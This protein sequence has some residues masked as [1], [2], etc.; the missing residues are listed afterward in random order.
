MCGAYVV[1]RYL[2]LAVMAVALAY[3]LTL[4]CAVAWDFYRYPVWSVKP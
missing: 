3:V 1:R 4:A 2:G